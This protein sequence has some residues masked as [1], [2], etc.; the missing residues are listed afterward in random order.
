MGIRR[1]KRRSSLS[2]FGIM[3]GIA[4][5]I[6]VLGLSPLSKSELLAQ[7]ERLGTD[8]L[9]PEPDTGPRRDRARC[10]PQAPT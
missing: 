8:P 5:M 7:L 2:A 1:R 4:T 6:A 10:R 3:I 9:T